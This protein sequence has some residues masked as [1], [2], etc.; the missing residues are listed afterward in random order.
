MWGTTRLSFGPC[1]FSCLCIF[2]TEGLVSNFGVFAD[3]FKIYLHY[4]GKSFNNVH[5][6]QVLQSDL[7]RVAQV[8][9]SWNWRLNLS[10]CVVLRLR[11]SF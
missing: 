8:A 11:K 5:G 3:D 4:N 1:S 10:K 7:N 2:L 6:M 9:L